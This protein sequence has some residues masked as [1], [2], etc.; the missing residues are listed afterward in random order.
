VYVVEPNTDLRPTA[1]YIAPNHRIAIALDGKKVG[2]KIDLPDGSSAT[3]EWIKP[4]TLHALH[5]VLNNF[6]N[7]YPDATGL[8][9]VR[10]DTSS[11]EGLEPMLEKLRDRHDAIVE[12]QKLYENGSM[13]LELVARATGSDPI[14]ALAGLA[15]AG[16]AI[17]A[18]DG[19]E[20]ERQAAFAAIEAN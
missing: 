12:V 4:K 8:E 18:C 10:F 1:Q 16:V 5:D 15:R 3:I 17:R 2:D 9:R 20:A 11:P 7:R 19:T 13:P 6:N 14:E